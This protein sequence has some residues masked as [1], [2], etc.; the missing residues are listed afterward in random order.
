MQSETDKTGDGKRSHVALTRRTSS[1]R[2]R[3]PDL[4]GTA[5]AS[6]PMARGL[7]RR[8]CGCGILTERGGSE[9]HSRL[10]RDGLR[11]SGRSST[12]Q[13]ALKG[14]SARN[15]ASRT[16]GPCQCAGTAQSGGASGHGCQACINSLMPSPKRRISVARHR[17]VASVRASRRSG[18]GIPHVPMP[19]QRPHNGVRSPGHD[20][21]TQADEVG[22]W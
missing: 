10:R 22:V 15:R 21:P 4:R 3:W 12:G 5:A 16:G 19:G 8:S 11:G 14:S 18:N 20:S 2:E 1:D 17:R 13:G 7:A 9:P 6:P